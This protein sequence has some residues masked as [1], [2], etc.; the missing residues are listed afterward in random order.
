MPP[1]STLL[2]RASDYVG[3]ARDALRLRRATDDAARD[4]A[5]RHLADRM[6]RL[7]GLPQKI[8]Q[9]LSM[10]GGD[11]AAD[12]FVDL[13]AGGEPL[14]F[15]EIRPALESAWGRPIESV[16]RTVQERGIAASLGQVH[17]ATLHDG[18][19]VAIKVQYPGIRD[20][21][22]NDLRVLG[23]LT[24]PVGGLRRGFDLAGYQAEILRD[25]EEELDYT[26]EAENQ[27]RLAQLLAKRPDWIVPATIP[28]LSGPTILVTTWESSESIDTAA[29]WSAD[30]RQ[31]LG[32]TITSGVLESVLRHGFFHA[33]PHPGNYG[34]RLIGATPQVVLYDFGSTFAIGDDQ[35]FALMRLIS[36]CRAQVGD[37]LP[38]LTML[39]FREDLLLP[40]RQKL[41]AL[42]SVLLEPFCCSGP[43]MLRRWQRGSRVADIL[44]D[45]RWNFR[46]SGPPALVFLL[47]ALSGAF[48]YV[49]RLGVDVSWSA[50]V[51]RIINDFQP[52]LAALRIP[53][54]ESQ[55]ASFDALAR[56]LC[57]RVTSAGRTHVALTFQAAAI[58]ELE[59]LMGEEI[60]AR[61]RAAGVNLA[62]LVRESRRRQY[63]P[64]ILFTIDETA[65]QRGVRVWLE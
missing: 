45:D 63:A 30:Q 14:P 48:Y 28:E 22:L 29:R 44:G 12:A 25:I 58:E 19:D 1:K 11:E 51:A 3:L 64:Q 46:I 4:A 57:I 47:R 17:R 49:E 18:R 55:T 65:T 6:G 23:W 56:K 62:E 39:G 35:R 21:L 36:M 41:P 20:A 32:R 24:L 52:Q 31:A 43:F 9:I 7:R 16:L 33:D 61:V 59:E 5:R 54:T 15:D 8:G 2:G 26:R 53:P 27:R 13:R 37:P 38:L 40:L 50:P 42:L 10:S 60:L 34:F